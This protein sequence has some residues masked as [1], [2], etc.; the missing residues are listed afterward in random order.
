MPLKN[1]EILFP[2]RNFQ[3]SKGKTL[4]RFCSGAMTRCAFD[5]Y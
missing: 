4:A 1:S 5:K 3:T 2:V